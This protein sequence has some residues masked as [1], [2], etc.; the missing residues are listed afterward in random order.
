[1]GQTLHHYLTLIWYKSVADLY[2]ETGKSRF[3]FVWWM[4]EPFIYIAIFYVV[5]GIMIP[6]EQE[7]FPSFLMCGLVPWRWFSESVARGVTSISS[8]ANLMSQV[9]INKLVFPLVVVTVATMKHMIMFVILLAFVLVMGNQVTSAWLALLVLYPVLLLF[10]TGCSC[11]VASL[12]P[13]Y[14][15]LRL[16][17]EHILTGLFFVSGVFF[18]PVGLSPF[19]QRIFDT[20][21]VTVMIRCFRSILMDGVWPP[22]SSFTYLSILGGSLITVALVLL[23]R[24]DRTYPKVVVQ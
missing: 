6:Q 8:N 7:D 13:F 10:L 23:L 11:V 24:F 22:T 14:P 2:L 1:M 16:L 18:D 17:T 15:D 12:E 4:I 19:W 9:Y 5:F 20:N 21:P 3:G